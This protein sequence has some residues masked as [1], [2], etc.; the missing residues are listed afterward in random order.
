M[1]STGALLSEGQFRCCVCQDVFSE[2]VSIPC[3]HSFCFTCITSHWD[4]STAVS[5][6]KC[7]TVFEHR[8]ELC[9][10]SF[11]REMSER[12]RAR[13]L[14]GDTGGTF[15]RCDVCVGKRTRALKSCTVCL[16][17][18][19]EPHLEAHL[20]VASLKLHKLIEPVATLETRT[21]ESHERLLELFCRSHQRCVCVLCAKTDHRCHNIVPVEKESWQKKVRLLFIAA[22]LQQT[23]GFNSSSEI[24]VQ[25]ERIVVDVQQM[26]QERLHKVDEVKRS[27]ALSRVS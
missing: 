11:A 14:N 1:A 18:Y 17:S 3:G 10:N 20:R 24:Q 8:P 23:H 16:T 9:E 27:V 15:I 7:R 26:I 13:R 19:C 25:I 4:S 6:P 22:S 12:I 5:C 2:P 21:C